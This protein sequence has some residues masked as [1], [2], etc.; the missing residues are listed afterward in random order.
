[1]DCKPRNAPAYVRGQRKAAAVDAAVL[2]YLAE[3]GYICRPLSPAVLWPNIPEELRC[4]PSQTY[5]YIR[6]S[7]DR[8]RHQKTP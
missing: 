3:H 6:Q 4:G 1:M 8:L 2:K 7:L 5:K